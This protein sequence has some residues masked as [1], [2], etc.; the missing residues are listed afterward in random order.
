MVTCVMVLAALSVVTLAVQFSCLFAYQ[1]KKEQ[2]ATEAVSLPSACSE[3][4]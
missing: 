3:A 4:A 1:A 2:T